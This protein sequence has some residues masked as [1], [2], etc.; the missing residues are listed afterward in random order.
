MPEY[1]PDDNTIP[2]TT[3]AADRATFS[4]RPDTA[5]WGSNPYTIRLVSE[6]GAPGKVTV[7]PESFANDV[8]EAQK[9]GSNVGKAAKGC[10]THRQNLKV[11]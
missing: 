7:L 3:E 11:K 1:W 4:V 8:N 5:E 2:A 6:C 10:M 9:Y